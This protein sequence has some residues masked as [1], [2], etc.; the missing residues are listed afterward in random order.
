M[1]FSQ[2]LKRQQNTLDGKSPHHTERSCAWKLARGCWPADWIA[3]SIFAAKNFPCWTKE[4]QESVSKQKQAGKKSETSPVS[5]QQENVR[6]YFA[7]TAPVCC[8]VQ[9]L[10]TACA[11]FL[12]RGWEEGP[13]VKTTNLR[14]SRDSCLHWT[15]ENVKGRTG[16]SP[17][18]SF[19]PLNSQIFPQNPDT[20]GSSLEQ[21]PA[22][23]DGDPLYSVISG[24]IT[25]LGLRCKS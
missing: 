8:V 16:L 6:W 17:C 13:D 21:S 4:M 23:R 25:Q 18:S 10:P 22:R 12:G 2:H 5:A 20:K 7:F 11:C 1:Q 3:R 24:Q 9:Q 19:P 14:P 15:W